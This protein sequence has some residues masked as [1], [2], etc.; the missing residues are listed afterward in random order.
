MKEKV[1]KKPTKEEALQDRMEKLLFMLNSPE[2]SCTFWKVNEPHAHIMGIRPVK[3]TT[4]EMVNPNGFNPYEK[5]IEENLFKCFKIFILDNKKEYISTN[6]DAIV[7]KEIEKSGIVYVKH[8]DLIF[9]IDYIR[10]SS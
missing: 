9:I 7:R 8:S 6:E 1:R 5:K 4:I 2:T 3:R 10:K